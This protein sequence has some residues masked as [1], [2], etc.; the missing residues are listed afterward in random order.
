MK[1]YHQI[2]Y[3]SFLKLINFVIIIALTLNIIKKLC[4]NLKNQLFKFQL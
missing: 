4:K 3:L 2:I 1:L